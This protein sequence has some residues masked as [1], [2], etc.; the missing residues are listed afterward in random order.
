VYVATNIVPEGIPG[1]ALVT[2]SVP[3]GPL[4]VRL[5]GAMV[6]EFTASMPVYVTTTV[7]G[8][9]PA[10][11][12]SGAKN[13]AVGP[14]STGS[15]AGGGELV[16]PEFDPPDPPEADPLPDPLA[17]E[18]EEFE[19]PEPPSPWELPLPLPSPSPFPCGL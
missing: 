8:V 13:D 10:V 11:V 1:L 7:C 5:P 19:F 17:E 12:M 16:P 6:A 4:T 18:P 15:G 14:G 3:A 9:V 2:A